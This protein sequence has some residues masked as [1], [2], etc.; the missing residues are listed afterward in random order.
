LLPVLAGFLLLAALAA[1]FLPRTRAPASLPVAD[2]A[3]ATAASPVYPPRLSL[4][5]ASR[6]LPL[7]PGQKPVRLR[8]GDAYPL[9]LG[10]LPDERIHEAPSPRGYPWILQARGRITPAFRRALL[11]AGLTL[12]GFVPDNALL[13]EAPLSALRALAEHPGIE[14]AFEFAPVQKF[15]P[16]L[17]ARLR[18]L[19]P[20]A[21]LPVRLQTFAPGEAADIAARATALGATNVTFAAARRRGILRGDLPVA[22]VFALAGDARVRYLEPFSPARTCNEHA[23]E[24]NALDCAALLDTG[25][26]TGEGQIVGHADTGLDKGDLADLHADLAGRVLFAGILNPALS[27]WKDLSNHGTH[28]AGSIV[29]TGAASTNLYRGIAPG[30]KLHHLAIG[31]GNSSSVY[32]PDDFA[33]LFDPPYAAGARIHSDSWGVNTSAYD[34]NAQQTD[35]YV[36]DHPDFLPVFAAGNSAKDADADGVVDPKS[37]DSPALGKNVLAVGA[38]EN[39]RARDEA[40]IVDR[41]Y[42]SLYAFRGPPISDDYPS[43]PFDGDESHVGMAPFS[44]R[45][46]TA[47]GRIKPDVVAPGVNAVSVRTRATKAGTVVP[48]NT[49][50]LF[51]SGTSQAVPR[52]AGAAALLREHCMK[53]LGLANPSAALLRAAIAGGAETLFPGQ[54]GEGEFLEIPAVRPNNVEGHGMPKV[55]ATAFPPAPLAAAWYDAPP[56]EEAGAV[57][58]IRFRLTASGHP[59]AAA[60]AWTDAAGEL[61]S[62]RQLVQDLDLVL[63]RPDGTELF[64]NGLDGP[65]RLNPMETVRIGDASGDG[66][67]R[68]R[69][70]AEDL[71]EGANAFATYIRGAISAIPVLSH[72]PPGFHIVREGDTG[73]ELFLAADS[74][75]MPFGTNGASLLWR[76]EG[77]EGWN[78]NPLDAV[79][80]GWTGTL[81][82]AGPGTAYEYLFSFA[83]EGLEEPEILGADGAGTPF[84]IA[85]CAPVAFTVSGVSAGDGSDR[86][87]GDPT[88]P[89]GTA[90]VPA[91]FPFAA[92]AP[93]LAADGTDGR[94]RFALDGFSLDNATAASDGTDGGRRRLLLVS[95]GPAASIAWRWR[96]Q[97]A[98][99]V[100]TDPASSVSTNWFD[101]GAPATGVSVPERMLVE[102][103]PWG[104]FG[105]S[106]D[107]D[108][109]VRSPA[110]P[111]LDGFAVTGACERCAHYMPLSRDDDANGLP[112]AFE[113]RFFGALGQDP[114]VDPDGDGF[115]NADEAAAGSDP[116]DPA[117]VPAA[118]T[119]LLDGGFSDSVATPAPWPFSCTATAPDGVASV[120]LRHTREG[121]VPARVALSPADPSSPTG[122]TYTGS[123]L[124][125]NRT[126][127]V[128]EYAVVARGASGL[129][130]TSGTRRIS[131]AYPRLAGGPPASLAAALPAGR[132]TDFVFALTNSGHLPLHLSLAARPYGFSDDVD[133]PLRMT[134]GGTNDSWH[135]CDSIFQTGSNA[136]HCAVAATEETPFGSDA[137]L[138]TPDVVLLPAEIAGAPRLSFRHWHAGEED[139]REDGKW[140]MY[141]AGFLEISAD[142]GETWER[143]DPDGGYGATII[144]HG[145]SPYPDKTPCFANTTNAD[146]RVEWADCTADLSPWA[147]RTV[148]IRFRYGTDLYTTTY[149]WFVDAVRIAP[150][151]GGTDSLEEGWLAAECPESLA[152]GEAG[153]FALSFDTATL[154]PAG[155]KNATLFLSHD[156]P[157]QASPLALF[158]ALSNT[159]RRIQATASGPGN[160]TP[161]EA[162]V[163]APGEAVHVSYETG[164]GAFLLKLASN[165]V[166]LPLP[167]VLES[168]QVVLDPA[169]LPDNVAFEGVFAAKVPAEDV[170]D[171][172]WRARYGL[173]GENEQSA[174]LSDGDDDGFLAWQEWHGGTDPTDG[175]SIP[176][177]LELLDAAGAYRFWTRTNGSDTYRLEHATALTNGWTQ[178]TVFPHVFP[179]VTSSLPR[180]PTGFWR[181][182][183]P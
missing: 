52:I 118:P 136:W 51:L 182:S 175:A 42:K 33:A 63:V 91:G 103:E 7:S 98:L 6:P 110:S 41:N 123:F 156:A 36:F 88:P 100:S 104:F 57:R 165:G 97:A 28:T 169:D 58:E 16:D 150:M 154:E 43:E 25:T 179:A 159:S 101:T 62:A 65:D 112:D 164:E 79:A 166:A 45:G 106:A 34:T 23:G 162:V 129:S 77:E 108:G 32:L 21:V 128:V 87:A 135:P 149:G 155:G 26:L 160:A 11:D 83:D 141:D 50:Y 74:W 27:S 145:H 137:W 46:P 80:G 126:G 55:S 81:P 134:H 109:S 1:L 78:A 67:W 39:R 95:P 93:L 94:T 59:L 48:A 96:P 10:S 151:G 76:T 53:N 19:S 24:P 173:D 9:P 82:A 158:C 153:A 89:Y 8:T 40:P 37:C 73:A 61:A 171:A 70:S 180:D 102:G 86:P 114:D 143:L 148:R 64:P 60:L 144:G 47:D 72:D 92:S 116:A 119:I 152:P 15:S 181:L 121:Y 30:A 172:A 29:G 147:G 56:L 44:G 13:V 90:S 125:T 146:G 138:E 54:Y 35:E 183:I 68:V 127:T 3:P 111:S 99:V 132:T 66:L 115:S 49:N 139:G 168:W 2:A 18:P 113:L 117:S 167:D 38:A 120:V 75:G 130:A 85:Y 71:P 122:G 12:H 163:R 176:F 105:W 142:G 31:Y 178:Q 157:E 133:E 170:P 131:V 22:A 69:V 14:G 140:R 161:E 174:S 20:D 5:V 17:A 177:R 124:P 107:G 4:A 84:R